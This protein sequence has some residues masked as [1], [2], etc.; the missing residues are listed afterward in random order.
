VIPSFRE[1]RWLLPFSILYGTFIGLP[2]LAPVFMQSGWEAPA[3]LIYSVYSFLCHQ[4]PERSYFLFGPQISYSLADIQAV[5]VNTL[6]PSVLRQFA[7]TAQMGWKVAWSDRMVSMYSS[8]LPAVWLIAGL[9]RRLG[10]LSF[11][12]LLIFAAPM[13]LDGFSH[14]IS[15][16]AGI[17]QGFRQSNLWLQS[18]TGNI[19]SPS[20]Y[21]GNAWGSFNAW[22]RL[23]TGLLFSFGSVWFAFSYVGIEAGKPVA[24]K[25]SAS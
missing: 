16:L 11:A 18:L 3:N 7:G 5:Y 12:G 9:G 17:E 4:L 8:V 15:D 2:F 23:I 25:D 13:A 19:L 14:M 20:F 24:T 1:Q 21:A 22:M 6:D 10:P